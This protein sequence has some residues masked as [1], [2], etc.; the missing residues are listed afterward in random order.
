METEFELPPVPEEEDAPFVPETE[1]PEPY[2]AEIPDSNPIETE[3]SAPVKTV[4]DDSQN[5]R[6]VP[7]SEICQ[8]AGPELSPNIRFSLSDETKIS[9]KMD[10]DVLRIFS[11]PGFLYER[12]NRQDVLAKFAAAASELSGREVRVILSEFSRENS[13]QRSLDELK[14]FSEVSFI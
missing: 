5:T 4:I 14:Q 3:E 7:W 10:G 2:K 6:T 12:L 8:K 11:A 9:G 13:V 1:E